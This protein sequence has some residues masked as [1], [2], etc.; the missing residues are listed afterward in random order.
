MEL[1]VKEVSHLL[2]SLYSPSGCFFSVVSCARES[3]KRF[4]ICAYSPFL[5]IFYVIFMLKSPPIKFFREGRRL[6]WCPFEAEG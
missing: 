1:I 6:K 3:K 4:S 2:K 5:G